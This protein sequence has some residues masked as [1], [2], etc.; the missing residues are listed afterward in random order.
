MGRERRSLCSRLIG[1]AAC[2]LGAS[3]APCAD[4]AAAQAVPPASD[5]FYE[6]TGRQV[7]W[8]ERLYFRN[9]PK[10]PTRGSLFEYDPSAASPS[11]RGR[12]RIVERALISGLFSGPS[13]VYYERD[14]DRAGLYAWT[15]FDR[16]TLRVPR[17]FGPPWTLGQR[18]GEVCVT[19]VARSDGP[20][21]VFDSCVPP[22]RMQQD[23]Q[24][25]GKVVA[26]GERIYFTR[27]GTLWFTS[28]STW[29]PQLLVGFGRHG[30]IHELAALGTKVILVGQ[31]A[32]DLAR[33]Y[34]L[35]PSRT[36]PQVLANID[37]REVVAHGSVV[38]FVAY[39]D[40][41][42]RELWRTDGSVAGTAMVADLAPG[43]YGSNPQQL[44]LHGDWLYFVAQGPQGTELYRTHRTTGGAELV[45][46]FNRRGDSRP[47]ELLVVGKTLLFIA[48]DGRTHHLW[49]ITDDAQPP[50]AVRSQLN[51]SHLIAVAGET[52]FWRSGGV[53]GDSLWRMKGESDELVAAASRPSIIL[54]GKRTDYGYYLFHPRATPASVGGPTWQ[55]YSA[56]VGDALHLAYQT[57]NASDFTREPW[58][59]QAYFDTDRRA[60]TGFPVARDDASI[61]AE[62]LLEG[63]ELYR[64][65][66]GER[67]GSWARIATADHATSADVIELRLDQ[68]VASPDAL[69]G[70]ELAFRVG[71]PR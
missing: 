64:Y 38:F 65:V 16:A 40:A 11:G 4:H 27:G 15:S 68:R 21:A 2:C 57:T 71:A 62:Y 69:I 9:L 59:Y 3:A 6:G 61:G 32:G 35:D 20:P 46:D 49:A 56:V 25:M 67:E 63:A 23:G 55:P 34:V 26:C 50:R 54:D 47:S 12:V 41:Y 45:E 58:R 48:G 18:A 42:G 7:V 33:P 70:S 10:D 14:D 60:A 66:G 1:M 8:N 5:L 19:G 28:A 13:G 53:W 51:A 43:P 29:M 22:D 44:T 36:E 37:V 24:E 17:G 39:S 30:E 52:Y 31:P